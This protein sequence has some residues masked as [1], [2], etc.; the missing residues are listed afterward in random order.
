MILHLIT[1]WIRNRSEFG[2][3]IKEHKNIRCRVLPLFPR[4][5]V[6][7]VCHEPHSDIEHSIYSN[8]GHIPQGQ[9]TGT[10]PTSAG[11]C[12][13]NSSNKSLLWGDQ[14]SHSRRKEVVWQREVRCQNVSHS[15]KMPVCVSA[16]ILCFDIIHSLARKPAQLL[17]PTP[18]EEIKNPFNLV[19]SNCDT[20]K[21]TTD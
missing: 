8:P 13:K 7:R 9:S 1:R 18:S 15:F 14:Q 10:L 16:T 5:A 4:S 2:K 19:V 17:S 21:S 11:S 3:N 12:V 6:L 20:D